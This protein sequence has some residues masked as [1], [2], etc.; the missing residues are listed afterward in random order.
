MYNRHQEGT[1]PSRGR[2]QFPK[3]LLPG[4]PPLK[5]HTGQYC[6]WWAFL[7]GGV[8]CPIHRAIV[9][10]V[11]PSRLVGVLCRSAVGIGRVPVVWATCSVAVPWGFVAGVPL[12]A[13]GV[14]VPW[15]LVG[16]VSCGVSLRRGV[17]RERILSSHVVSRHLMSCHIVSCR[18]ASCRVVSCHVIVTS[19]HVMSCRVMFGR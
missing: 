2:F 4:I 11:Y 6:F 19:C 1:E 7:V 18:V 9:I 17:C 10:G 14:L 3:G 13:S 12:S 5:G 8:S 15:G 16:G